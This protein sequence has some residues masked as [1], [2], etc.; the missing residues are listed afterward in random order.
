MKQGASATVIGVAPS[1][2]WSAS[3]SIVTGVSPW[4]NGITVDTLPS[5]PG[6]RF[7]EA[8]DMKSTAILWGLARTVDVEPGGGP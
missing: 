5:Q 6:E 4:Q 1:D 3:A 7:F 2:T 8:A